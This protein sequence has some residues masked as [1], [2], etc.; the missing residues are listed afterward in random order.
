MLR[1]LSILLS[2]SILTACSNG[3][4]KPNTQQ[5]LKKDTAV[6]SQQIVFGQPQVIDSSPIV[7]YPLVLETQSYGGSYSKSAGQRG[8]Y[9]NLI[10]YNTES[11]AQNLLTPDQKIL[12]YSFDFGSANS[13]AN[14]SGATQANGIDILKDHIIYTAVVK[15]YNENKFLDD[16]DPTYLFVSRRDGTGFRQISP[17]NYNIQSWQFVRGTTKMILQAQKND[18]DDKIFNEEDA[19]VPLIVDIHASGQAVET[20]QKNFVDSLKGKLVHIWKN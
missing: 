2:I 7:I 3:S 17:D 18:N 14:P 10:F 15:D 9:W 4:G 8:S 1:T 11:G 6:K 13:P 19:T 5:Q 12:I 20:F 16:D